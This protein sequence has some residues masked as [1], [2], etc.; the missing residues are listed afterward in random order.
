MLPY[1]LGAALW[2]GL[3]LCTYLAAVRTIL[4]GSTAVWV[5]LAAPPVLFNLLWGS[6]G[7][8]LAG[9][10]GAALMLLDT[11]PLLAGGLIALSAFKPQFGI[12]LP[13]VL[14]ATGRWRVFVAATVALTALCTVAAL[15]FGWSAWAA[16][17][18]AAGAGLGAYAYAA[19]TAARMDWP[20]MGS[21]YALLR[22]LGIGASASA[23]AQTVL[24]ATVLAACLFVVQSS[25]SAAVKNAAI[26]TAMIA[27]APY[28]E[29][30]DWTLVSVALMF[31]LRDGFSS[32]ISREELDALAGVFLLLPLSGFIL[33]LWGLTLFHLTGFAWL[34]GPCLVAATT[35]LIG[36]RFKVGG[37][38]A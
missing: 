38:K 4:P 8:L 14:A 17:A 29:P 13:F 27:G 19:H 36:R 32:G 30:N 28:S 23:A 9:L 2:L 6:N 25:A 20:N 31:L 7:M 10:L 37:R 18:E 21:V 15:L 26:L 34:I 35:A 24:L 1:G 16:F 11:R 33:S 5:A 12:V 3:G 22:V